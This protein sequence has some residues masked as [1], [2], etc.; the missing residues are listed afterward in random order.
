M[1]AKITELEAKIPALRAQ[2]ERLRRILRERAAI[3]YRTTGPWSKENALPL[4]PSLKAVRAQHLADA[5]A[6][7]DDATKEQLEL[8]ADQL[9]KTKEELAGQ[10]HQL[11]AQQAELARV[12]KELAGQQAELDRR[13][14]AANE[15]CGG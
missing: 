12:E 11:A 15:G 4:N 3:L 8:V 5:A 1:Q 13:V 9:T 7:S 10:Q 6:K 2:A 14:A